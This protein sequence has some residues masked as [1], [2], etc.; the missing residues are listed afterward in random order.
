MFYF[1]EH[2]RFVQFQ[3]LSAND[4]DTNAFVYS[5]IGLWVVIFLCSPYCGPFFGGFIVSGLNGAWRPVLWVVFAWSCFVLLLVIFLADETWYDRSLSVQPER[6][7]GVY[8]RFC[9]LVGIT[10]IRQRAY[11][12]NAF[13]SIMRLF[14]VFTKPTLWMVFIVYA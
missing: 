11:K 13:P 1:H 3:L 12:P 10:G 6:P 5:K 14:E 4:T 2:A 7:T 8:G 9:N